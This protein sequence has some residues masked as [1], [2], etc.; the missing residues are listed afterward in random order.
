MINRYIFELIK[1][2]DTITLPRPIVNDTRVTQITRINR[3]TRGLRRRIFTADDW[4]KLVIHDYT[5]L[6]I[7]RTL[8]DSFLA[9][10]RTNMG[11]VITV[12]DHLTATRTMYIEEV[13]PVIEERDDECSYTIG[14]VLREVL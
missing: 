11:G 14:L 13:A 4:Y 8:K 9:F 5:F 1:A 7:T 6:N 10:T 2:P 12:V 3:N